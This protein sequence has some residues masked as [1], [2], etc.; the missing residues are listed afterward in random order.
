MRTRS[1]GFGLGVLGSVLGA[2]AGIVQAGW[3]SS[4]PDWTGN[5]LHPVQLGVVTIVLSLLCLACVGHLVRAGDAPPWRRSAAA[6]LIVASAAVCFT[7]VGRLWF[8]PGP[9]LIA[10]AALLWWPPERRAV[11]QSR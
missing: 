11:T 4:I 2:A 8:V 1:I 10:A 3:G 9:L 6:F 7:T 5:K